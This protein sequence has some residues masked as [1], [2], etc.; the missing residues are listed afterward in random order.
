MPLLILLASLLLSVL[1]AVLSHGHI[2]V[3]LL[4]LAFGLPLAG[5]LRRRR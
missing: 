1:L 2:V 3:F 5:V 4:P